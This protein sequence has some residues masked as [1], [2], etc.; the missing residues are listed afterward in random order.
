MRNLLSVAALTAAVLILAAPAVRAEDGDGSVDAAKA[1]AFDTRLFG[2]AIGAGHG[3]ACF[4][5]RYDPTH[6][7][8]HPHQ[9]VR[10]MRLLVGSESAPEDAGR[11]Y[12]FNLGVKYRGRK[13]L[14]LS[15]GSCSHMLAEDGSGEVQFGCGVECDGGGL[16]VAL[17]KDGQSVVVSL[18]RLRIWQKGK[19]D[20]GNT[21]DLG[22]GTDDK[23]FRLERIAL[24]QCDGLVESEQVAALDQN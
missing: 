15:A 12:T 16:A 23:S 17:S 18:E 14:Y 5:R 1:A 7:A 2:S 9:K 10:E 24:K 8:Q 13:S 11:R 3:S 19:A 6:L 21:P 4:S 22:S 20:P